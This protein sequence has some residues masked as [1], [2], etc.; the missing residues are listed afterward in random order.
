MFGSMWDQRWTENVWE[1]WK[2]NTSVTV[3]ITGNVF[4]SV[5]SA[6]VRIGHVT[7]LACLKLNPSPVI[8]GVMTVNAGNV[9]AVR[10]MTQIGI[11]RKVIVS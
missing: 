6:I 1:K 4:T 8:T 9:S 11:S 2:K 7:A 10:R 3:G 5:Q